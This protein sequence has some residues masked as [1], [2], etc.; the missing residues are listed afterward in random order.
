MPCRLVSFGRSAT[1][2]KIIL[3][4]VKKSRKEFKAHTMSGQGSSTFAFGSAL[5][6]VSSLEV[7]GARDH[8]AQREVPS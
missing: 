1:G 3:P 6:M 5:Q 8:A 4:L 7:A 2:S